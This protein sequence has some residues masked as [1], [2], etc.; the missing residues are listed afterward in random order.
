MARYVSTKTPLGAAEAVTLNLGAGRE[1]HVVGLVFADQAGSLIIE[2][3]ADGSNWD[4]QETIA[5]VANTGQGFKKDLYAPYVR[6]RYVN[7][8]TPQTVF[9][10]TA[11]FSSAG[12]S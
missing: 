8:A 11:R 3:S 9:R 10:L 6:V 2:Q 4:L 12:D 5:V 1:D 7:G